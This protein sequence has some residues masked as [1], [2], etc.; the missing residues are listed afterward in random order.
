MK[1]ASKTVFFDKS[2]GQGHRWI[3][4][5]EVTCP[6]SI[7]EEIAAEILDGKVETTEDFIASNGQ[8]YAW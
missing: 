4:A 5:D 2:G 8:H 1:I 3:L 7:Q 6:A